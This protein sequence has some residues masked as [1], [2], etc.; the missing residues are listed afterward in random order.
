[1]TIFNVDYFTTLDR[2][3][4]SPETM[5][6]S[7]KAGT[8][9]GTDFP[10]GNPIGTALTNRDIGTTMAP[11]TYPVQ[12]LQAKI[13]QGAAKLEIEFSGAGKSGFGGR[14]ATPEILGKRE[15]EEFREL[16][17][18]NDVRVTTHATFGKQ[19]FSGLTQNG[20]S[21]EEAQKSLKE[22]NKAIEFAA[23]ATQGGAVVFHTG[24]WQRPIMDAGIKAKDLDKT[25]EEGRKFREYEKEWLKAPIYLADEKTG[26]IQAL[27]REMKF[28]FPEEEKDPKTGMTLAKINPKTGQA[29]V[30]EHTYDEALEIIKQRH[31]NDNELKDKTNAEV[32]MYGLKEQQLREAE[33]QA[34]RFSESLDELKKA[35]AKTIELK[36]IEEQ[37]WKTSPESERWKLMEPEPN[38]FL[39]RRTTGEYR[40][41]FELLKQQEADLRR[42]IEGN[43]STVVSAREQYERIKH[44]MER[45]KPIEE[46]GI[47]RTA[48]TLAKAGLKAME[49][50]DRHKKDLKESIYIA[51]ENVFPDFYGSNADELIKIV[52]ESR[53]QMAE[54]LK[55]RGYSSSEAERKAETHIKATFDTGHLNNWRQHFKGSDKEFNKWYLDQVQKLIDKKVLGHIHITDNWGYDD[56]HLTPGQGNTPTKEVVKML[57]NAGFKDFI[58][59][60]G[61]FNANTIL[62]DT[63]AELGSPVYVLGRSIPMGRFKHGHFGYAAPPNYIVGAY[64]PSN[65]FKLWSEVPLE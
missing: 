27:N 29:I 49:E 44:E 45:F 8:F 21:E 65:E 36:K 48:D 34:L 17:K 23:T 1:M 30:K 15:R 46:V 28:Y 57:E 41:R 32:L 51:P 63:L 10:E 20:F 54:R 22:I 47:K 43:Q 26:Q 61:S 33:G 13:R 50:T 53:N 40:P 37:I 62:P 52:Q 55:K 9:A 35:L 4:Y 14:G 12:E 5:D 58:A 31:S 42:Q 19:G 3:Y 25:P 18:L 39:D 59:E 56:E 60:V 6:A 2:G 16:A 38:R 24:E 7:K 64:S 11:D